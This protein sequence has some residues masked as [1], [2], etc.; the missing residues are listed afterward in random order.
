MENS[1]MAVMLVELASLVIPV[2]DVLVASLVTS[3]GAGLLVV[4]VALAI[5]ATSATHTYLWFFL[6]QNTG[7]SQTKHNLIESNYYEVRP[8]RSCIPRSAIY[9]N[10]NKWT[11][12]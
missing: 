3:V 4:P 2:E 1:L 10:P 8:V 9:P 5:S 12:N 7:L 6:L 11:G